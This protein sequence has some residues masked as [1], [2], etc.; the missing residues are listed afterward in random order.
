MSY[1][2]ELRKTSLILIKDSPTS[3]GESLLFG[4]PVPKLGYFIPANAPGETIWIMFSTINS[5]QSVLP[6]TK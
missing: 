5:F 2:E 1:L 4:Q 3:L 6:L